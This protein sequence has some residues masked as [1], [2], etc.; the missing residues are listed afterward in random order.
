MKKQLYIIR[1]YVL[2]NS[3]KDAIKKERFVDVHDCWLEENTQ[4]EIIFEMVKDKKTI[5]FK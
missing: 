1:K 3:A 2:A 5:G 4:R